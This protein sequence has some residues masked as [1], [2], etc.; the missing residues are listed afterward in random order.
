MA[1]RARQ[2]VTEL[3]ARP[4]AL[5]I[6]FSQQDLEFLQ[7]IPGNLGWSD[8]TR[9]LLRDF[10]DL[11]DLPHQVQEVLRED[12]K[13][14]GCRNGRDY[15]FGLLLARHAELLRGTAAP[16]KPAPRPAASGDR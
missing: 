16:F 10:R 7:S 12:M 15:C 2:K 6:Y 3:G 4:K 11:F 9:R 1:R 13:A 8:S 5:S 14:Q